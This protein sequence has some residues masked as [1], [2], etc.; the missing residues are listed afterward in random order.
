MKNKLF[1]CLILFLFP[2]LLFAQET[3]TYRIYK[4]NEYMTELKKDRS[5]LNKLSQLERDMNKTLR[6]ID[7]NFF[8]LPIVFHVLYNEESEKVS[9]DKIKIQVDVLNEAFSNG[10]FETA[11]KLID[12][13][14]RRNVSA[15]RTVRED[16]RVQF[17]FPTENPQNKPSTGINYIATDVA[18]WTDFFSMKEKK[19]GEKPWNTDKY[20]NVWVVNLP[21]TTAGFAQMPNG[22]KEFDGIVIDHSY[23]TNINRRDSS[24]TQ[25]PYHRGHTLTH[26]IGNYL[27]L[28]PLWGEFQCGDDYI[29]DTPIHNAPNFV[30]PEVN[31]ISLCSGNPTEMSNNF[32]DNTYDDCLEMFTVGQMQRI[33]KVLH[34]KGPRGKL[35]KGN[36][37]IPCRDTLSTNNLL[38]AE[39]RNNTLEDSL[40]II[41]AP[42]ERHP[43]RSNLHIRPNP[44]KD[45]F[46]INLQAAATIQS[47]QYSIEVYNLTGQ[48]IHQI[49]DAAVQSTLTVSVD[50]W[51]AGLYIV[52]ARMGN[53]S[54]SQ[55]VVVQ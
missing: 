1:N 16:T 6:F 5:T 19:T 31:H 51:P 28:L 17:C 14:D 27:G 50:N 4:T 7:Y 29:D 37:E 42:K 40:E 10:S 25:N 3:P 8:T 30:C 35:G 47:D 22:P 34:P 52:K 2:M 20:I 41:D 39:S 43:F 24:D 13:K 32:M 36:V 54:F 49:R 12:G 11:V 21:D 44:T 23:I 15:F 26:L 46:Y 18:E 53:Q 38:I 33:Q 48:L 55:R 45:F 9:E